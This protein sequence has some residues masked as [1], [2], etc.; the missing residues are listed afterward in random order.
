MKKI[1]FKII[2]ILIIILF[3]T[4]LYFYFSLPNYQKLNPV[5][6]YIIS[7][8]NQNWE[9]YIKSLE[10]EKQNIPEYDKLIAQL[11]PI[12]KN[13]AQRIL[14]IHPSEFG[15][16]GPYFGLQ[17]PGKLQSY[18]NK[19]YHYRDT[20]IE[21]GINYLNPVIATDLEKM[22]QAMQK[23]IGKQLDIENA[24]RTPGLSAKLFFHYLEKENDWS[25]LE[26]A[27]WVAMPGYSEH[28]SYDRTAIDF[29][30]QEGISG[31]DS[32]QVPDDFE[33]LPE[34]TWLTQ[35]AR[36]YNFYLTYPRNNPFGIE[37]EPWHWHWEI[38]SI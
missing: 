20:D 37:F 7:T 5:H 29:I 1:I 27:K 33:K 4:P 18:P 16:K 13:L 23:D 11:N 25:L 26:T 35:N 14:A 12:Q 15:F 34:F 8:I 22:N 9:K 3:S 21:T 2:V 19:K 6:R 32:N 24:Y 31:E 17:I 28:N 38:K 10:P 36:K 30:N